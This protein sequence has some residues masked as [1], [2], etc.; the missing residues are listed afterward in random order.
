METLPTKIDNLRN[1][2]SAEFDKI[3][4]L[5]VDGTLQW[6]AET[7][8]KF[9]LRCPWDIDT[10]VVPSIILYPGIPKR[11]VTVDRVVIDLPQ[12]LVDRI[13]NAA[14]EQREADNIRTGL[15][16]SLLTLRKFTEIFE[17][18]EHERTKG[19]NEISE[20]P[21]GSTILTVQ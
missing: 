9:V 2:I 20:L 3:Y 1:D 21:R 6:E 19:R 14:E 13:C 8:R 7:S 15:T 16:N 5:T 11:N 10:S 4:N 18:K 12:D 17:K